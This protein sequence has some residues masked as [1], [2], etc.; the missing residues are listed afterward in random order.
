MK[1]KHV[2][3]PLPLFCKTGTHSNTNDFVLSIAYVKEFAKWYLPPEQVLKKFNQDA[4]IILSCMQD[5]FL[6]IYF[7]MCLATFS[8]HVQSD[9]KPKEDSTR[10]YSM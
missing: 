4:A 2:Y 9:I 6:I 8:K 1:T 10:K 7:L 3:T 5:R